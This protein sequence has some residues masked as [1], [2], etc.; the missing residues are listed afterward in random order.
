MCLGG[1]GGVKAS[2]LQI[3]VRVRGIQRYSLFL[4]ILSLTDRQ[5]PTDMGRLAETGKVIRYRLL[6][7]RQNLKKRLFGL[8]ARNRLSSYLFLVHSL[9]RLTSF[10]SQYKNEDMDPRTTSNLH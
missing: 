5:L 4:N 6:Q 9:L 2:I 1:G 10:L 7:V 8:A 3:L